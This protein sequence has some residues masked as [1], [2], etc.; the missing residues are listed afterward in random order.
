MCTVA[1]GSLP[2]RWGL[3][4]WSDLDTIHAVWLESV[5]TQITIRGFVAQ[6]NAKLVYQNICPGPLQVQYRLPVDEGAAVYKCEAHLD[7]RTISTH[8]VEK[9]K[10]EQVYKEAVSAGNTAVLARQ[11][12]RSSDVL[13]LALGNLPS[14]SK[15]ELRVCLVMELKV[16][17]DGGVSFVLPTVLNPRY[18]PRSLH[19]MVPDVGFEYPELREVTVRQ[20]YNISIEVQIS[21]AH[22]IARVVSHTDPIDV[23]ISEDNKSAQVRQD[24]G[25]RSDHDWSLLLYYANPYKTRVLRETGDRS[26]TGLMKE[27]LVM[28]NLFPEVPSSSFSNN[29]EIIFIIDRSLSMQDENMQSA[30]ATLAIFLKS[31]PI[32]CFFNIISFGQYYE[33]LFPE[34][35]REYNENTLATACILQQTMD[36]DM[37]GTEILGPLH[38]V[39]CTPPKS[40]HSRQI[41]LISDGG[42][43]NVEEV[44]QLVRRHAHHTRVFAVGIGHGASTALI[45]GVARAG[46][47]RSEM[48]LQQD[49]LQDKVMGLVSSMVQET[50]RDVTVSWE[51]EPNTC[52]RLVPKVPPVIFGGQHLTLYARVPSATTVK[53]ISISGK[54]GDVEQ[55]ESISCSDVVIV[56][57]TEMSL[58]RLAARAQI[59]QW[60]LDDEEDVA[61]DMI[62]LSV[63][64]GV[65]S[66][67]TACVGVDQDG[68]TARHSQPPE[69]TLPPLGP[70]QMRMAAP[71]S[72]SSYLQYC[73]MP[74]FQCNKGFGT[75][76]IP[77]SSTS[78]IQQMSP[79][80]G[81]SPPSSTS[82][83]QQMSPTTGMIPPSSTSSQQYNMP[84]I[85]PQPENMGLRTGMIPPSSTSSIQMCRITRMSPTFTSSI[86]EKSPTTGMIPHSSNS[87]QQYNMPDINPQTEKGPCYFRKASPSSSSSNEVY[88]HIPVTL[89][90]KVLLKCRKAPPSSYSNQQN[91]V[92]GLQV[93]PENAEEDKKADFNI[94]KRGSD[95]DLQKIVNL[96]YFDGSWLPKDFLGLLA[97]PCD[98]IHALGHIPDERAWTTAVVL[99]LLERKF[100]DARGKWGLMAV[101]A[102]LFISTTLEDADILVNIALS[103]FDA[104]Q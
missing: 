54:V 27:D 97:L 33:L 22:E 49:M 30:R 89:R 103:I 36:S 37:G 74:S 70:G 76:M 87:S 47:G 50:V 5:A 19:H 83:I 62:A 25:F 32:G 38:S 51:L 73:H 85:N 78:S 24:G 80:T 59:N 63:S 64:S 95:A 56:H 17:T 69:A 4:G 86:Q 46:G 82:S 15:A 88:H 21:G 9:K 66:K 99:A 14:G 53:S 16:K 98:R 18:T 3:L 7:G 75:R 57:D 20:A 39:Y 67:L 81:M 55:S 71:S 101:K 92:T 29:N 2:P 40:G 52:V 11:D 45:Q 10:A 77:S 68:R 91:K 58:H 44:V 72:S 31:L 1:L 79:T 43:W 100:E 84:D 96:Q 90:N 12:E 61:E 42:V 23:T 94:L 13:H 8:C 35:S 102:R 93:Q 34:G 28:I 60:T 48:V 41:L 65:V 26:A 6:V 104:Q